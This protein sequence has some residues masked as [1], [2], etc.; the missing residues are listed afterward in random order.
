MPVTYHRSG[1]TGVITID[2]PPVNATGQAVRAGLIEA[3]RAFAAD[4]GAR[5]AVILCAGRTWVAGADISEFGKPPQDPSLPD[6][7]AAIEALEK[8]V[9]AAIHGTALGGGLELALGCHARIAAPGARMGL[10]EVT[11][12]LLPGAGGTQRLPRLIGLMPALDMITSARQMGAAEA[13]DLGLIDAVAP[14]DLTD[15]AMQMAERLA[16]QPP[17]RTCDL[18]APPADPAATEALTATLA[19]KLPGQIAQR[20]AVDAATE[21]LALPF[22]DGMEVE[23]A[24]FRALMDS[25]QRAALIHAFFAERAV[26]HLPQIR[27]VDP[28]ALDRIGVIGGGTMGAGIAAACLLA[29]L[30]VTLIERDAAAADTARATVAKLLDG[31]VTRGK[32][33]APARDAILADTFRTATDYAAL[34]DADLIIEAVFETMEVK[35]QVFAELDRVARPGAVLATNTSYLDVDAIAAATSRPAD[36]IGLH[37][38]SPAHVMRLLEVVVADRTAPEVTATGFALAKRL[39]K[40]AVRAGVCDGFIG[41]RILSHYRAAVDAMV[42][43]GASPYQ[44]D[45]A[46][47]GFGFA[48]GP[49]AVS[50]LAG[51]DIG[52]MTRQRKAATRH[53]RDRVPVFADRLYELGRLGRKSGRGYY[54]YDGGKPQPD[55]ELEPLLAQV[56]ADLGIAPR[57]FTDAQIVDRTMAALVNEAVRTVADGTALRPLDV[58]VVML[59][60]YGFPR[61]R[62]GPMHW[63]DAQGLPQILAQIDALAAED[64]HFWQAAPLLRDLVAEGRRLAELNEGPKP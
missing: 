6:V 53:P 54:L 63:A 36:V 57:D 33:A 43:D 27:G 47:T 15:A 4:E 51:L 12:G 32:L 2:N 64:D 61:W 37:F 35:H 45:R 52:W 28:R 10:P 49:Y 50:D 41:N 7:I 9:V 22:A 11:L 58:D 20:A 39:K 24:A 5:A 40:I 21:G 55:P 1:A 56:R 48:M 34:S 18:P 8:P 23:R 30:D 38:F 46:L 16:G 13:R 19:A 3:A 44:V 62:G 31:A 60:G 59:N 29:G 26:A 17:R 25:P 42:L 14:D